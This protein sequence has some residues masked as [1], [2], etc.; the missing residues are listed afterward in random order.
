MWT[1]HIVSQLLYSLYSYDKGCYQCH[2][3]QGQGRDLGWQGQGQGCRLQVQVQFQVLGLHHLGHNDIVGYVTVAP[4]IDV[5][6]QFEPTV[7]LTLCP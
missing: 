6:V 3:V 5:F 4:T 2:D 7:Y 1:R